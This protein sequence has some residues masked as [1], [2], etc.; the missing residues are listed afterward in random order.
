MQCNAQTSYIEVITGNCFPEVIKILPRN[1]AIRRAI[2]F[3]AV[4]M[5]PAQ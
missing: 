2:L 5:L 4:K 1:G 3:K